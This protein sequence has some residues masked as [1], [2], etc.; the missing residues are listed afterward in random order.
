MILA[1]GASAARAMAWSSLIIRIIDQSTANVTSNS[2]QQLRK[3]PRWLP[4][5][6]SIGEVI[7]LLGFAFELRRYWLMLPVWMRRTAGVFLALAFVAVGYRL[8]HF[9][10]NGR[11][12]KRPQST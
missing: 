5:A 12:T 6:I 4:W 1:K 11:A 10:R 7:L 8:I 2:R 3:K 9:I